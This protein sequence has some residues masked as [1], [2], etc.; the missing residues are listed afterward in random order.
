MIKIALQML[1][2][3]AD[4][5][6]EELAKI[7]T[8]ITDSFSKDYVVGS[9]TMESLIRAQKSV[10]HW[11][12]VKN[13]LARYTTEQEQVAGLEEWM[14]HSTEQLLECG[15]SRSTSLVASAEYEAEED[16]LKQVLRQVKQFV[17]HAR[18]AS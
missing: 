10:Y 3:Q 18:S 5:S 8:Q 1:A 17:S 7:R 6:V 12:K 14:A 16:E 4:R 2:Q 15:R 9:S 13:I 11:A